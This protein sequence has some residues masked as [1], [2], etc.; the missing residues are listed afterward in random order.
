M[1]E[2]T[3]VDNACSLL[4]RVAGVKLH[5]DPISEKVKFLLLGRWRGTLTQEDLP[6]QCQYI[7][8]SEHL[9]FEG[10]ELRATYV[11]TRKGWGQSN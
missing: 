8:L 3:M 6:Q 10:V 4:E 2:I 7:A 1:N 9:D 11:Q 5:R